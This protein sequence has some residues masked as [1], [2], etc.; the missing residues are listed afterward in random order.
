MLEARVDPSYSIGVVR[1]FA[2]HEF[3]KTEWRKVP[4][5]IKESEIQNL[6]EAGLLE[7]RN[8]ETADLEF[9]RQLAKDAG[10]AHYWQK[11]SDRLLADL[12]S[13]DEEE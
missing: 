9:L 8:H 4:D 1:A 6:G 5:N 7:F 2:G 11:K 3:I 13:L 12:D 10:I